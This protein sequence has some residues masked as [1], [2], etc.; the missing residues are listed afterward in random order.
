M[1]TNQW[2]LRGE[3]MESCNCDPGCPC[4]FGSDPTMDYCKVAEA[5]RITDGKYGDLSLTGLN[6]VTV[7]ESPGNMAD[8]DFRQSLYIDRTA[9]EPQRQ[10]LERIYRGQAGGGIFGVIHGPESV[11]TFAGTKYVPIQFD[12]EAGTVDIPGILSFEVEPVTFEFQDEIPKVVDTGHFNRVQQVG[13][14][15]S[16]TYTDPDFAMEWDN[17]THQHSHAFFAELDVSGTDEEAI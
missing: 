5:Y 8:G 15:L 12:L 2:H 9:D 14:S 7:L 17:S 3:Y 6:V 1:T 11:S 16:S 4:V 13:Y 10:A